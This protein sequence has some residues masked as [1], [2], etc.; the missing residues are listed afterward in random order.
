VSRPSTDPLRAFAEAVA[1]L[2]GDDEVD[3]ERRRRVSLMSLV[4][5]AEHALQAEAERADTA[6]AVLLAENPRGAMSS[7]LPLLLGFAATLCL[8]TFAMTIRV[9]WNRDAQ[10]V[11]I[12]SLLTFGTAL[13]VLAIAIT[14][15]DRRFVRG[16]GV[17]R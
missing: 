10:G 5:D 13:I 6:P 12:G 17:N 1:S 14:L 7:H 11:A 3:R 8:V 15:R 4:Q 16:A 2:A 9:A